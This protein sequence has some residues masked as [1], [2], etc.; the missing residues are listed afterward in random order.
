MEFFFII[1]ATKIT[2]PGVTNC[3]FMKFQHVH[4]PE[5][6]HGMLKLVVTKTE[7]KQNLI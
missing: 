6:T 1:G 7:S 5:Y 3:V 2:S 4:Y